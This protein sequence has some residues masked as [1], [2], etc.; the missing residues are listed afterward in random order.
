MSVWVIDTI[1]PKNG[2]D[3]PIVEAIDVAVDGYSSLADAVTHFA[4]NAIL[5]GAVQNLQNQINQIIISASAESVVAPE[6]A[7]ARVGSDGTSYNTLKSRLDAEN[8][9]IQDDLANTAESLSSVATVITSYDIEQGTW[10]NGS[11]APEPKRLRTKNKLKL[12]VGTTIEIHPNGL[13][14]SISQYD[15]EDSTEASYATGWIGGDTPVLFVDIKS[16]YVTILIA[17]GNSYGTSTEIVVSD[18]VSEIKIFNSLQFHK[19]DNKINDISYINIL[20]AAYKRTNHYASD[21]RGTVTIDESNKWT[22]FWID[23]TKIDK[24]F[25]VYSRIIFTNDVRYVQLA[26]LRSEELSN[27]SVISHYCYDINGDNYISNIDVPKNAAVALLF[28]RNVDNNGSEYINATYFGSLKK[29]SDDVEQLLKNSSPTTGCSYSGEKIKLDN[30]FSYTR[31]PVPCSGQDGCIYNDLFFS[32]TNQGVC[33]VYNLLGKNNIANFSVDQQATIAPHC[34]IAVFGRDKFDSGDLF[35][36]LYVNAYNS[37]GIPHGTLYAHRIMTDENGVPTGTL[38][39]QTIT[40][41]F[42]DDTIWGEP[43]NLSPYGNFF[44]D[45]DR[46]FLYAYVPITS[47]G[48]TRFFKFELPDISNSSVVLQQSDILD[49]FDTDYI[50]YPQ[51]NCYNSGKA[52]ILSGIDVGTGFL[53]VVNLD[54]KSIVSRI[55]FYKSMGVSWEPEVI[56]VYKGKLLLGSSMLYELSF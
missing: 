48:V 53:N 46:N 1:K 16:E 23:T 3:F 40:I 41:G 11:K 28:I 42:T 52:Y 17:N 5:N 49:Y 51:G 20:N 2:L 35:P 56:D 32:F 30:Y 54:S 38:L 18:Y 22:T 15:S 10:T 50:L 7:A 13:Y 55:D 19:T 8:N 14:V 25:K 36:V 44:I 26:F 45:T 43:S 29:I 37:P 34:N 21:Y 39:L 27:S 6:V 47:E 24:I 9:A 31:L 33:K 4:T 12:Q